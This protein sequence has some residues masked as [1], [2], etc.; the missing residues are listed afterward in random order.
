MFK[1][2]E[3]VTYNK[4]FRSDHLEMFLGIFNLEIKSF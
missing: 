1:G 2:N 3:T 4:I